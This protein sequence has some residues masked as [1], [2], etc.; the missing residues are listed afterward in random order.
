LHGFTGHK[1][2]FIHLRMLDI[3]AKNDFHFDAVQMPLNVMDAHFR[4]FEDQVLP[5]L[6]KSE[7]GVEAMKT[8]GDNYIL[9]SKTVQP[10][11]ALHYSMTL[12]TSVVITGIDNLQVLDQAIEAA[13]TFKPMTKVEIAALLSRTRE[14]AAK[15]QFELYKISQHFH[16]TA[17]NPQW[18]GLQTLRCWCPVIP[19]SEVHGRKPV[20][21]ASCA[22]TRSEGEIALITGGS[23]DIGAAIAK[24]LAA[25]GANV[26]ITVSCTPK[27][28]ANAKHRWESCYLVPP[29]LTAQRGS[30]NWPCPNSRS[31]CCTCQE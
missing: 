22:I 19:E 30:T 18:L 4:S 1:D 17:K 8:F 5:V 14:A 25:D 27:T 15:G 16:G 26:A 24:R 11:E 31:R 7:I 13:R 9:R 10:M 29:T 12:P 3:A 2:P 21:K 6:L 28:R 23:R 20:E